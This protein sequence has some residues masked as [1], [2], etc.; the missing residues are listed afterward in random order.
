MVHEPLHQLPV[1]ILL[2][3]EEEAQV[4]ITTVD[5]GGFFLLSAFFD[6]FWCKNLS[7]R[8]SKHRGFLTIVFLTF[9][10]ANGVSKKPD[11]YCRSLS[12]EE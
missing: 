8:Y 2:Q 4:Y 1:H 6:C 5:I 3:S 10:H 9:F 12:N 7:F 11:V